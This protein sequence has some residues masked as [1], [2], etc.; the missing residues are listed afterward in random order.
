MMSLSMSS[1]RTLVSSSLRSH[2]WEVII[3][4]L[5]WKRKK[6]GHSQRKHVVLLATFTH[7]FK[8]FTIGIGGS[9]A[10]PRRKTAANSEIV[11]MMN[12]LEALSLGFNARGSIPTGNL[13]KIE[14]NA[15]LFSRL[16]HLS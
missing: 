10:C 9:S 5:G 2:S 14:K 6:T 13:I 8:C 11:A 7:T 16:F 3:D 1:F 12:G 4:L 15:E